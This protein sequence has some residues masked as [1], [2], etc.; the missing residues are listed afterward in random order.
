MKKIAL[1]LCLSIFMAAPALAE[2]KIGIIDVQKAI[3]LSD[4]GKASKSRLIDKIDHCAA[5]FIQVSIYTRTDL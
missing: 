5:V 4:A 3:A 2:V 1:L